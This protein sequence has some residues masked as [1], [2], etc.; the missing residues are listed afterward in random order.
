MPGRCSGSETT[1]SSVALVVYEQARGPGIK[2]P[3]RFHH[4]Y[5]VRLRSVGIT[6]P[7]HSVP[8]R[9]AIIAR[10][11]LPPSSLACN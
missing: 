11:S 1:H 5:L 4:S 3:R 6:R 10:P 7:S 8:L 2:R 9:P